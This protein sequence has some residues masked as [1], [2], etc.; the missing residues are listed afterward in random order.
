MAGF[1]VRDGGGRHARRTE[2]RGFHDGTFFEHR[3]GRRNLLDARIH[4]RH[5]AVVDCSF[6]GPSLCLAGTVD[7]RH[8]EGCDSRRPARALCPEGTFRC[9]RARR[10]LR[11]F[12]RPLH[13][14]IL[15]PILAV[16]ALPG[17]LATGLILLLCFAF[18][19]CL[20]IAAAGCSSALCSAW[21]EN[22]WAATAVKI[23]RPIAGLLIVSAGVF[24]LWA[25]L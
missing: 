3:R 20:P 1:A 10:R 11:P 6:C 14:R 7:G 4:A 25:A 8:C 22:R 5:C 18:G 15:A 23:G 16:A 12:E 24:V 13:V 19:H 9:V 17:S 21:L 2:C